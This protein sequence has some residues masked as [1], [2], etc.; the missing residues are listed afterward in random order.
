MSCPEL[1]VLQA[2]IEGRATPDEREATADHLETCEACRELV[3]AIDPPE[4]RA[5][6]PG[7]R[8]GRWPR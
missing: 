5:D 6:A 1:S 3:L 2:H 4:A 7:A 8:Y